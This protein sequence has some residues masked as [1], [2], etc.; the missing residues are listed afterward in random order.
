MPGAHLLDMLLGAQPSPH[1]GQQSYRRSPMVAVY[2][3][4]PWRG[5]GKGTALALMKMGI[6]DGAT[7]H[8]QMTHT[9]LSTIGIK[10]L[11]PEH[12]SQEK[13]LTSLQFGTSPLQI[14]Q[15][16]CEEHS[17]SRRPSHTDV[18]VAMLTRWLTSAPH[19]SYHR[20]CGDGLQPVLKI[21]DETINELP[22]N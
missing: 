17:C 2:R 14:S 9:P 22:A 6:F 18:T 13:A 1:Q 11:R 8:C 21:Q 12:A 3:F 4:K 20:V 15:R 7:T 5:S 19:L 10:I 16:Y